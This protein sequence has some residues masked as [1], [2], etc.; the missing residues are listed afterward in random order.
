MGPSW[1][2]LFKRFQMHEK[3]TYNFD[4]VSFLAV[5]PSSGIDA[6]SQSWYPKT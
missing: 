2:P 6:K 3:K 4:Q 1:N 5:L